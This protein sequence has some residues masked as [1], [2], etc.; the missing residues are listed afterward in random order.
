MKFIF[1]FFLLL[2]TSS[3]LLH[4]SE[5]G[6][7]DIQDERIVFSTEI[8]PIFESSCISCHGSTA[9]EN[10][11]R[12]DSWQQLIRGSDYS[13][14]VI[15][16]DADNSLLYEMLT[17]LESPHL[18]PADSLSQEQISRIYTWI[19]EGAMDDE[20]HVPH[21]S[22]NEKLYVCNQNAGLV[23]VIELNTWMVIR[24]IIFADLG[25]SD[26]SKP[27]DV[28]V[29]PDGNWYVS[30]IGDGK[31][32]KFDT[33]Y[34]LIGSVDFPAA[35]ILALNESNSLLYV[36]HTLSTPDVPQTLAAIN[37]ADMTLT[38]ISLPYARPHGLASGPNSNFVFNLSLFDNIISVIDVANDPHEIKTSD[39]L[40]APPDR[41][42]VQINVAPD[43]NSAVLSSQFDQ[44][45]IILDIT[46]VDSI[47]VADSVIVGD[48]PWHP[49]YSEDGSQIFVG[50]NLSNTV[51]VVSTSSSLQQKVYGSG[52]GSDG[53]AQPHG[54]V[55]SPGNPLIYVSNRNVNGLYS[56]RYDFGDNSKTGTVVVI[57]TQTDQIEKII[58]IEAF[59]SGIAI[60]AL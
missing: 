20:G 51:S 28:A 38:Q 12:L 6:S 23:S 45:L 49:K 42:V 40:E 57:N 36:G 59:P 7:T 17:K 26:N 58:E 54:L 43:N 11:L 4:C 33:H 30:L 53:L 60:D 22:V 55:L 18:P 37:Y 2:S 24:N 27:H 15:P 19:E 14:A 21:E 1:H 29:D 3:L 8:Q 34:N 39:F 47:V 10:N 5:D 56:P 52:D 13:E 41:K 31:V 16:F 50:N 32:L 48:H 35:G 9:A 44:K 46:N 25:F